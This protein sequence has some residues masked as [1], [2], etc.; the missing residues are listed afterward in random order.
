M[1]YSESDLRRL[2]DAQDSPE[3]SRGPWS[4]PGTLE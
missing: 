4:Y 1:N 3:D 2:A